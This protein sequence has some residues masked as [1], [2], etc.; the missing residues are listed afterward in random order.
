MTNKK[1]FVKWVFHSTELPFHQNLTR[2]LPPTAALEPSLRATWGAA[3]RTAV[4]GLPQLKLDPQLS[5]RTSSSWQLWWPAKP[6]RVGLLPRLDSWG[7]RALVPAGP[8]A[9]ICLLRECRRIWVS[10]CWFLNLPYWLR[11]RVLF[12]GGAGYPPPRS[13]KDAGGGPGGRSGAYL[14]MA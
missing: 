11:F 4:L 8:L 7:T 2:W 14:L 6:A 1:P 10:L 9:P 13:R 3:S 5:S 12:G